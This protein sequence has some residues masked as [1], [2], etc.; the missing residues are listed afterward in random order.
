MTQQYLQVNVN[1]ADL[2]TQFAAL[3]RNASTTVV[4]PVFANLLTADITTTT[5]N[6]A[7]WFTASLT[8]T[9]TLNAVFRILV[10][11]APIP[12]GA[13]ASVAFISFVTNYAITVRHPVNPGPHR[14]AIQWAKAA[15]SLGPPTI[16]IAAAAL[17]ESF[18][19]GLT[20]QEVR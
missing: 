9:D 10:D 7:I 5:G 15:G 1:E 8:A 20:V 3:T 12:N 19:A 6:L 18:Q 4:S 14:V 16:S 11:N 2:Q 13:G 17:P